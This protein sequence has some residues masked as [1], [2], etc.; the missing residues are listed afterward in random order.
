MK[1]ERERGWAGG[2]GRGR[3]AAYKVIQTAT[4]A[5]LPT[6]SVASAHLN[7]IIFAHV[8]TDD[9]E[10]RLGVGGMEPRCPMFTCHACCQQCLQ[11]LKIALATFASQL[12]C[13]LRCCGS[14]ARRSVDVPTHR[15][16]ES[17]RFHLGWA[18]QWE[19]NPMCEAGGEV[20]LRSFVGR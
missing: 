2:G 3:T 8:S 12:T 4:A 14:C 20:R 15:T 10:G 6:S 19:G 11:R 18:W 17:G 7:R 13:V 16:T 9:G 1:K 5:T